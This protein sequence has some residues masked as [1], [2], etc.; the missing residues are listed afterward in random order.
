MVST[1]LFIGSSNGTG[2]FIQNDKFSGDFKIFTQISILTDI[3]RRTFVIQRNI[4]ATPLQFLKAHHNLKDKNLTYHKFI[5]SCKSWQFVYSLIIQLLLAC[6][7]CYVSFH[8]AIGNVRVTHFI[9]V[10]SLNQV[11]TKN[12]TG[13][14]SNFGNSILALYILMFFING[15]VTNLAMLNTTVYLAK[16]LNQWNIFLYKFALIFS[17]DTTF[18]PDFSELRQKVIRLLRLFLVFVA[19]N[20]IIYC[21]ISS[22][23]FLPNK[24]CTS[25]DLKVSWVISTIGSFVAFV[26]MSVFCMIDVLT[27]IVILAFSQL[28]DAIKGS[29]DKNSISLKSM[30]NMVIFVR[31]Q[32]KLVDRVCGPA[33]LVFTGFFFFTS[34]INWIILLWLYKGLIPPFTAHSTLVFCFVQF[35]IF[36]LVT[37]MHI[38]V[39]KEENEIMRI[40]METSRNRDLSP[41][42]QIE[43]SVTVIYSHNTS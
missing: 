8:I 35:F 2:V 14:D 1:K 33:L 9:R 23:C 18:F 38:R 42:D 26:L 43:V 25:V 34:I 5:F 41:L 15:F 16:L 20:V 4:G 17:E 28:K 30:F 11:S 10:P 27:K 32:Y 29:P 21:F 24:E 19:S 12:E 37:E 3:F 7:I 13:T 22:K 31:K 36:F 6:G 39:H 40:I